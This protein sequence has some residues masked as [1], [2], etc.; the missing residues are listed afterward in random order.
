LFHWKFVKIA[1]NSDNNTD[2]SCIFA[3]EHKATALSTPDVE[4]SDDVR[5][6]D[7]VEASDEG[8]DDSK[9]VPDD[10]KSGSSV[11]A[12]STEKEDKA[13]VKAAKGQ[14]KAQVSILWNFI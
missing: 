4:A 9:D 10:A 12:D 2:P 3:Q 6:A 7:D 1:K 14:T 5:D 13:S 8:P 11:T